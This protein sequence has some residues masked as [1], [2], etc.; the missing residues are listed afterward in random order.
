M[1]DK[2]NN[3]ST[4][5]WYIRHNGQIRG[6][7]LSS[8]IR[9]QLVVGNI[10]LDDFVSLDREEWLELRNVSEVV[11]PEMR[12]EQGDSSARQ[13][14]EAR[15][16]QDRDDYQ[17]KPMAAVW[18]SLLVLV[19]AAAT[20][21]A[22]TIWLWE[23]KDLGDPQCDMA[24]GPGIDWRYCH[25][26]GLNLPNGNFSHADMNS[27]HL[28]GAHLSGSTFQGAVLVYA[29]LSDADL[30]YSEMKGVN[31]KGANLKGAK[32]IYSN[33]ESADLSFADLSGASLGGAKLDNARLDNAIWLDGSKCAPDSIGE[34]L[35]IE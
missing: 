13:S 4:Q 22:I 5:R 34:C 6:P 31:L 1:A 18:G 32:L 20:A 26:P 23:P 3:H 19:L 7:Y 8:E 2:N 30:S 25:K 17:K 21:I 15:D 29:D 12:S 10:T 9:H 35:I 28:R 14:L 16:E 33:L 24:A 11:P 27:I